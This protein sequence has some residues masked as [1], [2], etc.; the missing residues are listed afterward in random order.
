[1][2]H[3]PHLLEGIDMSETQSNLE[4][5]VSKWPKEKL[6]ATWEAF[7]QAPLSSARLTRESLISDVAWIESQKKRAA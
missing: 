1:M 4:A 5:I 2:G 3:S 7:F 6:Q